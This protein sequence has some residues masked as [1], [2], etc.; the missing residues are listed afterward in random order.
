MKANNKGWDQCGNAQ[1]AVDSAKQIIVAC[2]VTSDSNDKQQSV[3][4]L[5]DGFEPMLEQVQDTV[6]EDKN[7]KAPSADSGYYSESNV[8][9]AQDKKIDAYIATGRIKHNDPV[10]KVPRGRPP[11]EFSVQEKMTRKLRT[12]KG[13]ENYSKRKSIVEP[14]FGQI[15]WARGFV[16]PCFLA[17]A[18]RGARP[19]EDARRVGDCLLDS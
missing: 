18:R 2:D 12:K 1:A 9:F 17:K 11:K 19:R 8:R 10:P 3:R 6:G 16:P 14:V 4:R 13:R 15:N 7:I 5:I